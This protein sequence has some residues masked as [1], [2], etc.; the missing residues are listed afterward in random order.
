MDDEELLVGDPNNPTSVM[1]AGYDVM[2]MPGKIKLELIEKGELEPERFV[3]PPNMPGKKLKALRDQHAARLDEQFKKKHDK[4]DSALK[5]N[6][7]KVSDH[8]RYQGEVYEIIEIEGSR[9]KFQRFSEKKKKMV[10]T[11]VTY[12]KVEKG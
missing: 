1:V 4:E 3:T 8:V 11:S 7:Y 9:V 5:D 12:D 10:T 6:P 2:N